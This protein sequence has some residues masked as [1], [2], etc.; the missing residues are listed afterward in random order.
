MWCQ[1]YSQ[2]KQVAKEIPVA[3]WTPPSF[4]MCDVFEMLGADIRVVQK[5]LK[6]FLKLVQAK[7]VAA[8]PQNPTF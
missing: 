5:I 6:P 7:S 8:V 3:C 4:C 1:G 2:E